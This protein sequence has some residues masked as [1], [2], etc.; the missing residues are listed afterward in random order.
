MGVEQTASE[1]EK[2]ISEAEE[3]LT[4][5]EASKQADEAFLG[6][7]ESAEIINVNPDPEDGIVEFTLDL[8]NYKTAT[9]NFSEFEYEEGR[10]EEFL[11]NIDC[12]Q[13]DMMEAAYHEVPVTYTNYKG[14]VVLYGE[15]T[16][17]LDSTFKGESNWYTIDEDTAHPHPNRKYSTLL[18]LPFYIGGLVSLFQWS[19]VP[20][21]F[22]F[23]GMCALWYMNCMNV[24]LSMPHRKPLS[25]DNE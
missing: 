18:S 1:F 25:V 10:V 12:T 21:F 9:L 20:I 8:P 5:K 17:H 2:S 3:A 23:I 14:W 4:E 11:N 16:K 13:S 6:K 19:F 7:A 24:G 15:Y 22:G